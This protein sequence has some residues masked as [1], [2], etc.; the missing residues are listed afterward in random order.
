M[1]PEKG[2]ENN[3]NILEEKLLDDII[4]KLQDLR[5]SL[6]SKGEPHF[7]FA[8]HVAKIKGD[9]DNLVEWTKSAIS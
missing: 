1:K 9:L 3:R 7:L 8:E 6:P 5:K 4:R 2:P